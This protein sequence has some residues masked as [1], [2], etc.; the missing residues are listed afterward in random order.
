M[1]L[2]K[3]FAKHSRRVKMKVIDE[4]REGFASLTANGAQLLTSL[5]SEY[6]AY[7]LRTN[8]GFGVALEIEE[9][10][11]ISERFNG[12]RFHTGQLR[13]EGKLKNYIFLDSMFEDYRYEFAS[14]CTE[15][16]EPGDDGSNRTR[17]L[18]DPYVWWERWKELVGNTSREKRVY[19]VIAEMIALAS[20]FESDKST[21]WAATRSGSH[22]IECES[23]SC[24]VKSTIKRYGATITISG[25]HQLEHSKPLFLYFCRMEESLE[26]ISINDAKHILISKGYDENRL[27]IELER[28][29]FEKGSNIRNKKYKIIEKRK[30]E[31]ND[32]F[33]KIVKE[34]FKGDKYPI[35][36]VHIEYTV[37]L[38]GIGYTS[39]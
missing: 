17:I 27:E 26:G 23:E 8:D 32:S 4:I 11:E 19:N 30:Y 20:K 35:S 29:G 22:D 25:Q 24:E 3:Q 5:P 2:Q 13:M 28:Q 12:C 9:G 33:P 6:P 36:V 31:V 21:E 16:V 34:S 37:D 18:N 7:V 15:F 14:L 1:Q 39:W 38:D 10:F